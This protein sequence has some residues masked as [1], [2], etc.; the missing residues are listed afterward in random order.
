VLSVA[1]EA[2]LLPQ[3]DLA[4]LRSAL[5]HLVTIRSAAQRPNFR[6]SVNITPASVGR[7]DLAALVLAELDHR[8]LPPSSLWL[9]LVE[10]SALDDDVPITNLVALGRAGVL[11][12]L[13]DF[14]TGWSSLQRLR[15]VPV[16]LLKIDRAFVGGLGSELADEAI[17]QGLLKLAPAVGVQVIAEGVETAVQYAW[18]KAHGC[19]YAQGY[20]LGAPMRVED[21]VELLVDPG[22]RVLPGAF[23]H[24]A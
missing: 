10:T 21:L 7:P 5:E 18:L 11:V 6:I 12:A 14:G 16:D 17:V 8:G 24:S 19:S 2:G 13:D 23:T 4:I 20:Y 22:R 3:L 15:R 1:A 9:E